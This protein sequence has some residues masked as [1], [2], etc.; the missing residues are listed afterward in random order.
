[1]DGSLLEGGEKEIQIHSW[2]G[3]VIKDCPLIKAVIDEDVTA[4]GLVS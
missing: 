4:S 2:R 3:G 1:M